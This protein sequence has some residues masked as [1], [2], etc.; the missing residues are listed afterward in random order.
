MNIFLLCGHEW[1]IC[2]SRS[3][4]RAGE[5]LACVRCR[6]CEVSVHKKIPKPELDCFENLRKEVFGIESWSDDEEG[7]DDVPL[8]AKS[9]KNRRMLVEQV[10]RHGDEKKVT[11]TQCF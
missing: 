1:S 3:K 4:S 8:S 9:K 10:C 6:G 2:T 11:P 5:R 7:D